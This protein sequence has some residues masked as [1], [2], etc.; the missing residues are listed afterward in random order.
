MLVQVSLLLA[1]LTSAASR[2]E[3]SGAGERGDCALLM[4]KVLCIVLD[5]FSYLQ[6]TQG[7]QKKVELHSLSLC[8]HISINTVHFFLLSTP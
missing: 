7:N 4:E 5:H 3:V 8:I 6:G 2:E 1:L